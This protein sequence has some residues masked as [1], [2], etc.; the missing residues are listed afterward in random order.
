MHPFDGVRGC[1]FRGYDH[2]IGAANRRHW[3][4]PWSRWQKMH[5]S[6]PSIRADQH[7][8]DG[9]L[10]LAM[11][12]RIVEHRNVVAALHCNGHGPT[13]IRSEN[14]VNIRIELPMHRRLVIAISP[15]DH[16]RPGTVFDQPPSDPCGNRSLS[17]PPNRQVPD[18][19]D[20]D[21]RKS[22]VNPP[23][24]IEEGAET[25]SA[26]EQPLRRR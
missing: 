18:T 7:D 10:Q 11:L 14:H 4:A 5:F 24:V 12:K 20:R 6:R 9:S 2:Q 25:R 19:D 21:R 22:A 17:S 15:H 1:R 26:R 8:I 13:S 23:R 3:L 16:G